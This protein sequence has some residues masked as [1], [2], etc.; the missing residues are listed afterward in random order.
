MNL[1]PESQIINTFIQI[2]R[3][4]STPPPPRHP[5]GSAGPA[6]ALQLGAL[7][8]VLGW[9]FSATCFYHL[10]FI[11]VSFVFT[12]FVHHFLDELSYLLHPFFKA[13]FWMKYFRFLQ[14]FYFFFLGEPSPTRVILEDSCGLRT[15][16]FF[17][18][19]VFS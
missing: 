18:K 12:S 13:K 15:L 1:L 7:N 4:L 3:F 11:S 6:P 5:P 17:E 2:T 19:C 16:A 10:F 14:L 8:Y 9:Y